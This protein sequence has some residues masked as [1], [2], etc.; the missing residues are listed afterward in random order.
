MVPSAKTDFAHITFVGDFAAPDWAML[1][2]VSF[3]TWLGDSFLVVNLEG[4]VIQSDVATPVPISKRKYNLA[5]TSRALHAFNASQTCFSVA[6]NH[7]E[8]FKEA[9]CVDVVELGFHIVGTA[10]QLTH[11]VTLSGRKA[12][13]ACFAFPATDPFR[14]RQRNNTQFLRPSE[15]LRRLQDLRR[16]NPDT[17][18]CAYVHWGYELCPYP[19]PADRAWARRAANSG[20]DLIVGHHPHIPQ[21]IEWFGQTPVVYSLGNFFVPEGNWFGKKLTYNG[22][23]N[24]SLAI[25]FDGAS[26]EV[27]ETRL[28]A[29][30][31]KVT[32]E[33]LSNCE[34]QNSETYLGKMNDL[35]YKEFF[36]S[37]IARR[38]FPF[39]RA[40][41]IISSYD[42]CRNI[43][44]SGF[45][46]YQD[47]RQIIRDGLLASGL[48]NPYRT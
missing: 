16:A 8:D 28:N 40:V 10:D 20:V 48:R 11:E 26:I 35:E 41:P 19:F 44:E 7:Y 34:Q 9:N 12:I 24:S 42:C 45:F 23:A 46:L 14:W 29:G 43:A 36:R 1:D 17:F 3:N 2:L 25:R 32:V 30:T 5:S 47:L 31:G 38:E 39:P 13:I 27:Y 15:A 37:K 22:I 6:N 21:T 4:P 18:L 33:Q